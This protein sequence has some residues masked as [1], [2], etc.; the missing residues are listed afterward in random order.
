MNASDNVWL[1][2][3]PKFRS[4]LNAVSKVS[5]TFLVMQMNCV[6]FPSA[7]AN[8]LALPIKVALCVLSDRTLEEKV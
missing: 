7:H 8:R 1:P 4:K 6:L 3:I 2:H 5:V